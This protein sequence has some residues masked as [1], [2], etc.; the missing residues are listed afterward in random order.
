MVVDL[1]LLNAL[2]LEGADYLKGLIQVAHLADRVLESLDLNELL[3]PDR[4]PR[5]QNTQQSLLSQAQ[6]QL[7][8]H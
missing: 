7:P 8:K 4:T 5:L 1:G 3:H 2:G 6:R